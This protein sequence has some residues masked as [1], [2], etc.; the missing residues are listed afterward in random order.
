MD[1]GSAVGCHVKRQPSS[2]FLLVII[3]R[4]SWKVVHYTS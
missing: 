3:A 1:I 2:F 4:F